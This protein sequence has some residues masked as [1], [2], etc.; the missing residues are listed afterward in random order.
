MHNVRVFID[1]EIKYVYVVFDFGRIRC[2]KYL[3]TF[4]NSMFKKCTCKILE[5]PPSLY[6]RYTMHFKKVCFAAIIVLL[7]QII[8]MK[9]L[10]RK[11]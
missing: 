4:S 2:A 11:C 5:N 6:N 7:A 3:F 8:V 9:K 1:I 10:D